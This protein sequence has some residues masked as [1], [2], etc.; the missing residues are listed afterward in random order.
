MT[1]APYHLLRK[2]PL[3][4]ALGDDATQ[5]LAAML[6]RLSVPRGHVLF[7]RGDEG[8][9]L[10]IIASGRV[11][12]TLPNATGEEIT[13]AVL[14]QGEFFGEMALL[15]NEPRAASAEVVEDSILYVLSRKDFLSFLMNHESAVMAVLSSLSRR[16]RL[17]DDLVAELCFLP[18][19][20][21]IA[22]KLVGLAEAARTAP[23][24]A[25]VEIHTTQQ[26]IGR[27]LGLS[28]ET[29]NKELKYL[30]E[31]G[32]VRTSRGK[33]IVLNLDQ[34]KRRAK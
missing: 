20:A 9:V 33:V 5:R 8:T 28:R 18:A 26:E 12:I 31:K 32:I 22:R 23:E 19:S 21:R 16:L 17:T 27:M 13:L 29:I 10:Y 6:R 7:R 1:T 34:L 3:F 30:R 25:A 4:E 11:A 2:I 15:D 24:S 14:S